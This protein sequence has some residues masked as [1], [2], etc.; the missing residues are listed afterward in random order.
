MS[1]RSAIWLTAILAVCILTA[2]NG[3]S[4]E[5][6]E[7]L[8]SE[9]PAEWG[10]IFGQAQTTGIDPL[11]QNTYIIPKGTTFHTGGPALPCDIIWDRDLPVTLRDGTVIYTDVFRP[12]NN[13]TNLP[14]I[15]AWSPYG[16]SVPTDPPATVPANWFSGLAKSEGP[17]A[18]FWCNQGYAV[19][20]PDVRGAYNSG[21]NIHY[22]GMVDAADGYDVVEWVARQKWSNGKVGFHGTSWLAIAQWYIAATRPPHLAAIAPW[23]GLSD[24]YRN[25]V[26]QGGIPDIFF[27]QLVTGGLK[28]YNLVEEPWAMAQQYPLMNPYWEDKGA[29]LE[30]ITVPAYVVADG[31]TTLHRFGALEGFRRISSKEKWL[32]I[33][34]TD[35]WYDQYTPENEQDLLRFFDHYLKGIKNDWEQTPRVRISVLD[36]GGVDQVN[37]PYRNWPLPETQY[38][39][40]YLDAADGT[41]SLHPTVMPSYVSYDANAGQATFTIR[42]E[43]DTEVIGYLKLRLWVEADGADDM[44]LFVLVQKLDAQGN[45]LTPAPDF[46]PHY[47]PVPPRGAPGRLRASLRALDPI[48]STHFLPIQSFREQQLLTAGQIVPVD[49][50]IFPEAVLWHA[51][52]QLRLIVTG[53][54]IDTNPPVPTINAGYHIIHS[55]LKYQSYLQLPMIPVGHHKREGYDWDWI[56]FERSDAVRAWE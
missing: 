35:E 26:L 48:R 12:A 14:A 31:A 11:G 9:Y 40:F 2:G 29:K 22:W 36:P 21:G 37:V 38:R 6:H 24:Q 54:I 32:R 45:V 17:D 34:N 33:N 44:D 23:N 50:A 4:K 56:S 16:K 43:E 10:V 30:N 28:G 25:D 1:K 52:E 7:L 51:G 27:N 53:H 20:N 3:Y 47:L 19:V 5:K 13:P 41:L 39:K 42:F 49:V 55:G 46:A 8:P 18:A 15:I